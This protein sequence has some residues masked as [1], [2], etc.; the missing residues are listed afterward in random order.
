MAH[1][2]GSSTVV[3]R[4]T[5]SYDKFGLHAVVRVGQSKVGYGCDQVKLGL[6]M[7]VGRD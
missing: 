2:D 5:E 1:L 7:P 3:H 6:Q 4:D